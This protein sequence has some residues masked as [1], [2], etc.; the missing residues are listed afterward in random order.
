MKNG[1]GTIS[2]LLW[3]FAERISAQVVTLVVSIVLARLLDPSHYGIVA[4]VTV[5]ITIANVFVSDGFG[6]ALIQKKD[7]DRLDFSSV[8]IANIVLAVIL[9]FALFFAAPYISAFY[10][11]GYEELTPVLRVL[12]LRLILSAINTVQQAYVSRKMIFKK[13]FWATLFGTII[14]AIVGIWMAYRGYGVWALVAQYLTNTTIDTIILQLSLKKWPGLQFSFTRIKSLFSYGWKILGASLLNN[15]YQELRTLLI[16]K[17]YSSADLAYYSKG[18]QF[19]EL[20][21]ININT[22]IGSVMFPKMSKEQ[23][24][25]AR[26]K[27]TTRSSIRFSSYVLSPMM[28]GLAAVAKTFVSLLLTDK[29][30]FAVPF[31]QL[32][33]IFYLAQPIHTANMQAIKALGRSD[34]FFH[35]E[36]VKKAIE[37][38]TLVAVMRISVLAIAVS[39]TI[40]NYLFIFINSFPNKKLLGYSVQ[41]QLKDIFPPIAMGMVMAGVVLM[42]GKIPVSQLPLMVIQII[43]GGAIY[44][45]MSIFFRNREFFELKKM[46]LSIVNK[47]K[48]TAG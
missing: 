7:A 38:I 33:C 30:L 40:L 46:I 15:G 5:F 6:S 28:F 9:Y 39:A 42:L 14:S 8:L 1:S 27:A 4:M 36:I 2:N 17:I 43:V 29:W 3:K 13:F 32:Y 24:N 20:L 44:I 19:P 35:L 22:S 41:E 12:S 26:L 21:V 47:R 48:K 34:T 25:I 31:L 16:G 11:K 23:D 18:K 45:G 37:L 10:G